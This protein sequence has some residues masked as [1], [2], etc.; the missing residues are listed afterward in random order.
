MQSA[1]KV[2][3][4]DQPVDVSD[5]LLLDVSGA[6]MKII[7]DVWWPMDTRIVVEMEN[8]V[9]VAVV[10]NVNPRGPKF[11]LG[12][13]KLHSVLK[14]TLPLD[15]P[16]E[17]WHKLLLSELGA[18]EET[19]LIP[20]ALMRESSA[21]REP[22]MHEAVLR[23]GYGV[24]DEQAGSAPQTIAKAPET[25]YEP[26]I[27]SPPLADNSFV[28][29]MAPL[30]ESIAAVETAP[31]AK[32]QTLGMQTLDTQTEE[33]DPVPV[34]SPVAAD[35]IALPHL[36]E[37]TPLD[38]VAN[39]APETA[40]AVAQESETEESIVQESIAQELGVQKS[41][42]EETV[43]ELGPAVETAS[44]ETPVASPTFAPHLILPKENLAQPA[45][46]QTPAT[47]PMFTAQQTYTGQE[48]LPQ[49]TLGLERVPHEEF[50]FAPY[51]AELG[52]ERAEEDTQ[53]LAMRASAGK[54]PAS[55]GEGPSS[56]G[57]L[58]EIREEIA[59]SST[60]SATRSD[61]AVDPGDQT[62]VDD[63]DVN[64]ASETYVAQGKDAAAELAPVQEIPEVSEMAEPHA[65]DP[66]IDTTVAADTR[67][68]VDHEQGAFAMKIPEVPT[69]APA[70]GDDDSPPLA[71]L[72]PKM[73]GVADPGR[74]LAPSKIAPQFGPAY[75]MAP[76]ADVLTP[77][78]TMPEAQ[79]EPAEA[80]ASKWV[81]SSGLAAALLVVAGLAFYYGPFRPSA[82]SATRTTTPVVNA[83]SATSQAN[84]AQQSNRAAKTT[85]NAG[86]PAASP[87]TKE[88]GST[89]AAGS[90]AA[91]VTQPPAVA[92]ASTKPA[93]NASTPAQ[94][95]TAAAKA[96]VQTQ[97]ATAAK[98]APQVIA[99]ATL[100]EA[101]R[102]K[103]TPP[104][105][106]P[107]TTPTP[108]VPAR[109]TAAPATRFGIRHAVLKASS[110]NW[111]SVCSDTKAQFAK[112]LHENDT[113]EIDFQHA[114]VFHI[115]TA[116][117]SKIDVDGK[118]IGPIG[119]PG[120][121]R[122]LEIGDGGMQSLTVSADARC[123]QLR[124]AAKH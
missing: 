122:V 87:S 34:E 120:Q 15:A 16:R 113:I 22:R 58:Q 78:S 104:L 85:A 124:A 2:A 93:A 63:A 40:S 3:A 98:P 81:A 114:A 24:H 77:V 86:A 97:T 59:A 100:P 83:A 110:L 70:V 47:L 5:A 33:V 61:A 101:M 91:S 1:V 109:T 42:A 11:S 44:E 53:K 121:V 89:K 102:P 13:E 69:E 68:N 10:R 72:L 26:V 108:T 36:I 18:P 75:G 17:E 46:E 64:R 32:P 23:N 82:T 96:A 76:T 27:G 67:V 37:E 71:A 55:A 29:A 118:D 66:F 103:A 20:P 106:A 31:I 9:V 25:L 50:E 21:L 30:T 95:T 8:H 92:A 65:T 14:H 73:P 6:G 51:A 19:P 56:V 4:L 52:V 39:A 84:P 107:P 90:Q 74:Y 41:G 105:P 94:Q 28:P 79:P 43:A 88:A 49:L 54:G 116:G 111:V 117:A 45:P 80:K 12:A 123:G 35:Q 48:I 57:P 7:A 119:A 38:A 115:G 62:A 60:E 99:K 112:V